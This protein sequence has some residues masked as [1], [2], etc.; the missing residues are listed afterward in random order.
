[1][2]MVRTIAPQP[3]VHS[4]TMKTMNIEEGGQCPPY[5]FCSKTMKSTDDENGGQC[6]PT[7][8]LTTDH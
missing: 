2:R 5:V 8:F 1:M 3:A 7:F 4:K 6:P